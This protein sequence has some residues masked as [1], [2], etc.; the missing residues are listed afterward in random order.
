MVSHNHA[1]FG[2]NKHC[3]SEDISVSLS[4]DLTRHRDRKVE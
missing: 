1:T 4:R 2:G 3:G